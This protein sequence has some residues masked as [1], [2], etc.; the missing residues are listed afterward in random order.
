MMFLT[1]LLSS[2]GGTPLQLKKIS[3]TEN[4]TEHI[5][6]LDTAVHQARIEKVNVLAPISYAKAEASLADVARTTMPNAIEARDDAWAAGA[7]SLGDDY[8]EAEAG[9]Q[10]LTK[11][12]EDN[13]LDWAQNN[14]QRVADSFRNLEL[15][16]IKDK[17]LGKARDL[18]RDAEKR[19]AR[20][21]VPN[22]LA[23]AKKKLA[24]AETFISRNRYNKDD[25]I[26]KANEALFHADRLTSMLDQSAALQA[27]SPEQS[28]L[29]MENILVNI[30]QTL[31]AP[32]MRNQNFKTQVDN[33][34]TTI[35]GLQKDREF[36]TAQTA[37]QERT[38][39]ELHRRV[40]YL[41]GTTKTERE[42]V[43]RLE[44]EERFPVGKSV[45][46]PDNYALLSKVQHASRTF[47]E[48]QVTIEGH[49]DTATK[50]RAMNRRIDVVISTEM[51]T[52]P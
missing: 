14:Q 40:A 41:E 7:V 1:S 17:A 13:N 19:E 25:L 2:C 28:A 39:A 51:S 47:G 12:I 6:S 11:E 35:V 34:N 16:A 46:V 27:K 43:A 23:L 26:E 32:D 31:G 20:T 3:S 4:P 8:D 37:T 36:V 48:P 18:I 30:A 22:T 38:N 45:I 42:T 9:F 5:A 15:L 21:V 10:K 52:R 24:E 44:E 29:W 49:T 33:I 50:G